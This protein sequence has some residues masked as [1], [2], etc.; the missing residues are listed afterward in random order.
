MKKIICRILNILSYS[1]CIAFGLVIMYI[2]VQVFFIASFTIPTDSMYP[3]IHPGDKVL[4]CKF[5]TGARLFDYADAA[6]GKEVNIKRTPRFF[7]FKRNDILVFNFPHRASW[8]SISM[9]WHKYYLKRCI[10]IPGD[11]IEIRDF[12]YYV[13]SEALHY[14]P[15]RRQ[16][17]SFYPNDSVARATSQGYLV[18]N[19]DT[20]NRWTIREFGP[21]VVPQKETNMQLTQYNI[22][23]Y[24]QI[25]EWETKGSV[26]IKGG[27]IFLNNK[28]IKQYK[29][30]ENYYF[31]AGDY[32][33][34]SKD[35]RY[36]GFVPDPFIVGK[37]S[38]VW[39][40]ENKDGICWKRIFNYL[41]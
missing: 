23:N 25:I 32:A 17:L 1:I 20:I 26:T 8:D 36:W 28:Q 16:F 15:T 4:V 21:L 6:A 18:D 38:I 41:R 29:F 39:W 13:N 34:N 14:A 10:G 9:D 5:L 3:V 30:K 24:Q 37:A 22:H 31:M 12:V 35:S 7:K 19:S 11:T 2:F 40:S 33:I 27:T